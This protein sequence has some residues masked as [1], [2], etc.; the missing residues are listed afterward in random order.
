MLWLEDLGSTNGTFVDDEPVTGLQALLPGD[1]VR[2]GQT[3]LEV[4]TTVDGDSQPVAS[5]GNGQAAELNAREITVAVG[6]GDAQRGKEGEV[7]AG[8]GIDKGTRRL[9]VSPADCHKKGLDCG[10]R[11]G[12]LIIPATTG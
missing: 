11:S 8:V 12:R 1:I 9:G 10:V 3:T 5:Q 4:R 7:G 2:L 6:V